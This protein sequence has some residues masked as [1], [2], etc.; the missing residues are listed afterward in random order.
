MPA[1]AQRCRGSS[2]CSAQCVAGEVFQAAGGARIRGG[3]YC[4]TPP[5]T[6]LSRLP[7]PP[8]AYAVIFQCRHAL[9]N[10]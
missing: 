5:I 1:S 4:L 2:V 10:A 9:S 6:S 3:E 7:S 8:A